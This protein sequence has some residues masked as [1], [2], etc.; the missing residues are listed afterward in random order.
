MKKF[1]KNT[2]SENIVKYLVG[3]YNDDFLGKL[4]DVYLI[5]DCVKENKLNIKP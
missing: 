2:N 5:E 3:N 1:E 4:F